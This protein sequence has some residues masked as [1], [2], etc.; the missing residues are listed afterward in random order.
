VVLCNAL[1]AF[2]LDLLEASECSGG[3]YGLTC[4]FHHLGIKNLEVV[5]LL[6]L[7]LGVDHSLNLTKIMLNSIPMRK[8]LFYMF[9][10]VLRI[11]LKEVK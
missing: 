11:Y 10:V 8:L 4:Y 5:M 9:Y 3:C 1:S 2:F 6:I 7:E